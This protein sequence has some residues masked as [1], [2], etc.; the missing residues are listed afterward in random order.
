MI[1]GN[2]VLRCKQGIEKALETLEHELAGLGETNRHGKE[3]IEALQ[4][5]LACYA[6]KVGDMLECM[7]FIRKKLTRIEEL[8]EQYDIKYPKPKE[9]N[10]TNI[11]P[12]E[13]EYW[14]QSK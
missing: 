8:A 1:I 13:K 10:C 11:S 6:R 4:E 7:G 9:S 3:N 5:R 14:E 12:N 2:P